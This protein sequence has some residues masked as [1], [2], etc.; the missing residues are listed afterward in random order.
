[1]NCKGEVDLNKMGSQGGH[2]EGVFPMGLIGSL[3]PAPNEYRFSRFISRDVTKPLKV[4]GINS[5]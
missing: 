4:S 5:F 3:L 2:Y 1:A